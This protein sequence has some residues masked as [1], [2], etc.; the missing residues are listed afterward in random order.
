MSQLGNGESRI[1]TQIHFMPK[2]TLWYLQV[3][4]GQVFALLD[5]AAQ[6]PSGF[7]APKVRAFT[8]QLVTSLV[9]SL[10]LFV[11][12]EFWPPPF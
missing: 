8:F 3:T 1:H 4:G 10:W 7:C 11:S 6:G 12:H 5:G 2:A 9:L